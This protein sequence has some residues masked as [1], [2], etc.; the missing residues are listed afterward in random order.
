M[1]KVFIYKI[2]IFYTDCKIHIRLANLAGKN[3]YK[4]IILNHI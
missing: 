3:M 1:Q 4:Y 2:F